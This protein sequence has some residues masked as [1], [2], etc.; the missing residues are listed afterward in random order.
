MNLFLSYLGYVRA[1][2]SWF[3]FH[4]F[5]KTSAII[6]LNVPFCLLFF[7]NSNSDLLTPHSLSLTLS[8]VFS[9]FLPL[10]YI[11]DNFVWTIF[12]INIFSDVSNL[13]A[14]YIKFLLQF[15]YFSFLIVV[16]IFFPNLQCHFF[17]TFLFP[18]FKFVICFCKH[19]KHGCFIMYLLILIYD[20]YENLFLLPIVF[21]GSYPCFLVSLV[22]V[23]IFDYMLVSVLEK[24]LLRKPKMKEHLHLL[25]PTT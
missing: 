13:L 22:C 20:A 15:L 5:W 8:S 17:N 3:I 1:P 25:L 21:A 4:W 11:L 7:W 10:S 19:T 2:E 14:N 18:V 23:V 24:L 16:F 12:Q 9:I 6:S